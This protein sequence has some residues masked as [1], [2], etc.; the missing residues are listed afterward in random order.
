MY[1]KIYILFRRNNMLT[2]HFRRVIVI[3]SGL[4]IA[5]VGLIVLPQFFQQAAIQAV[6]PFVGSAM[7]AAGLTTF[8][9]EG[10]RLSREVAAK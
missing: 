6:M 3:F 4:T 5:G 1:I 8:V 10:L 7:F 9:V 2:N